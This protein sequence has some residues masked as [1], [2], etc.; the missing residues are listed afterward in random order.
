MTL[1]RRVLTAL[2]EA[3]GP[4]SLAA[5]SRQLEVEPSALE[6]MIDFWVRKGR[7]RLTGATV[8]SSAGCG[9]CP[10]EGSAVHCPA[11]LVAPRRYEVIPEAGPTPPPVQSHHKEAPVSQM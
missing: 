5:L 9:A 7:L 10:A 3:Q 1:L 4:V 2:E 8:C 11:L 6:G